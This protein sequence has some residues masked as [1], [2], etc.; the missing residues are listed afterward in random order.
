MAWANS[1]SFY[2]LYIFLR[3]L[4]WDFTR[5]LY[6]FVKELYRFLTVCSVLSFISFAISDHL[7]PFNRTNWISRISSEVCHYPL[8]LV[9]LLLLYSRIMIISPP[10]S[11]LFWFTEKSTFGESITFPWDRIPFAVGRM[12]SIISLYILNGL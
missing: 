6:F 5:C 10:L 12:L 7:F 2:Y 3:R 4:F 8:H 11:A 9:D 1:T